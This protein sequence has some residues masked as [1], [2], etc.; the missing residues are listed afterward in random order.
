MVMSGD[1]ARKGAII[2]PRGVEATMIESPHPLF[3]AGARAR[4]AREKA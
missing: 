3:A 1:Q 4:V 2:R